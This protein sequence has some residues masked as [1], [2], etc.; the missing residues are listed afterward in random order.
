MREPRA[1]GYPDMA[2]QFS[3]QE[4]LETVRMVQMENLDIRTITLG[5]SL[6]DCADADLAK[7]AG[8]VYDKICR[9]AA[10]LGAVSD[11]I[12]RDYGIPIVNK[13]ISVT[14]I[15]LVAEA[16]AERRLRR[17]RRARSS[18]PRPRSASTSS[19]GSRRCVHKGA[20]RGDDALIESIPEALAVTERVCASVNVG[21]TRA[22]INMDAVAR[23]G[24]VD[25][26]DRRAHRDA[27]RHRLREARRLLPTPSRTTP[28]WPAPS[29][30]SASPS[31]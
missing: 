9:L 1:P 14:P 8:K 31:A 30:A 26:R 4:I 25:P 12:E 11:E 23:M 20:T 2:I 29:T 5:I 27:R 3:P 6:L 18:A 10:R 13:R 15:A 21:T 19:A 22:G 28:S 24:E 16:S 17:V 7:A